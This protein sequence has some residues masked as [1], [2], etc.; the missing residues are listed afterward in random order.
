MMQQQRLAGSDLI[1]SPLCLGSNQFGTALDDAA[2]AA[3]LDAFISAGGNFIDTARSYGDWIPDAPRG[4]SERTLGRLL[5]CRD[6]TSLV[7]ATKGCEFDYR[8]GNFAPR[9]TPAHLRADLAASLDALQCN[10]V[11]L[12]WLHR[13]DSSRPVEPLIDALIEEQQAGRIRYFGCSNW[14]PTRIAEGLAYALRIGHAGFLACQ[15][16]WGLAEPNRE[17]MQRYC[18]GGY[19]EDGYQSLH[20]AGLT[21]IPYSG[22]SRGVF[23]KLAQGGESSLGQEL[24]DLYLNDVNRRRLKLVQQLAQTHN[25][26]INQ[27]V[28]AYLLCQKAQ[29][30]P[31]IGA[32]HPEQIIDSVGACTLRLSTDELSAMQAG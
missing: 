22:Q 1:V 25:A 20:A 14:S 13:D 26:S 7:I 31:I 28:L 5:A 10:H 4:A 16:L 17:A 8:A 30:I 18:P 15:P 9:V 23:S 21:M 11:D 6:R 2:A 3:I 12:Y 24:L 29:T 27:V 32:S 19:Y